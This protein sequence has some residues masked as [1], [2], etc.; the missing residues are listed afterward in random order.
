M[1]YK[2]A[3][4]L[5]LRKLFKKRGKPHELVFLRL[6]SPEAVEVYRSAELLKWIP[7]EQAG[8]ILL[9]A[10]RVLF[11]GEPQAL[12]KLGREEA[13]DSLRGLAK[14]RWGVLSVPLILMQ[15]SRIWRNYYDQG[16]AH[17]FEEGRNLGC[18]VA[19]DCPE[20]PEANREI[21]AG[22]IQEALEMGGLKNPKVRRMEGNPKAW[23]WI[24]NSE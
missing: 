18:L 7:V 3:M 12:R 14:K 22:F 5:L 2:A 16:R 10:A 8:E 19:E 21:L 20:L 9:A 17:A 1:K 13:R 6:L 11:P 4:L 15:V 24:V 23:K